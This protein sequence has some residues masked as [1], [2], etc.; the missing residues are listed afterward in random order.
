ML[1]VNMR[2]VQDVARNKMPIRVH[3][4]ASTFSL[5]KFKNVK[6]DTWKL[7]RLFK[8]INAVFKKWLFQR[9]DLRKKLFVKNCA[10]AHTYRKIGGSIGSA[11]VN[12]AAGHA[13]QTN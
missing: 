4:Y 12:D 7:R 8:K 1:A 6:H 9:P 10:S 2:L 5:I 3:V 11:A 13:R